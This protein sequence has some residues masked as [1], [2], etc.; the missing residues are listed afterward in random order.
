[1]GVKAVLSFAGR[2][3]VLQARGERSEQL[4]SFLFG[5]VPRAAEDAD[6]DASFRVRDTGHGI[7]FAVD[8]SEWFDGPN[9][10]V[11][12][13]LLVEEVMH[14]LML[15]SAAGLLLH[16]AALGRRGQGL[17]LPGESGCG[18]S[19]T[20]AW[21]ASRGWD[22]LTDELVFVPAGSLDFE[23]FSRPIKLRP[24]ARPAL[25]AAGID[26]TLLRGSELD[27][28]VPAGNVTGAASPD[29]WPISLLVFPL[30]RPTGACEI[31]PLTA[32]QAGLELM[33]SLL[34]ARNLPDHGFGEV[35]R[36]ARSVPAVRL[37]YSEIAHLGDRLERLLE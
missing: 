27:L 12:G 14:R 17:L 10:E 30:H 13:S 4:V 5:R 29:E 2:A 23:P 15:Q 19:T 22:Y 35:A 1:M 21:L 28:L 24:G 16:A 7:A 18:K 20:A 8:E 6:V 37:L 9:E 32:A 34:N 33:R 36:I 3:V 26:G 31:Q 11:A 25:Q